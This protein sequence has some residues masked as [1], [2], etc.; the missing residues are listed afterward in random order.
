MATLSDILVVS[1]TFGYVK[2][3]SKAR[4]LDTIL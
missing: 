1:D 2:K 3:K 4:L